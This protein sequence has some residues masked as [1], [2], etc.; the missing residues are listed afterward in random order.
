M[1]EAIQARFAG[2]DRKILLLGPFLK[3]EVNDIFHYDIEPTVFTSQSLTDLGKAGDKLGTPI[4]THLKLETGTNRQGITEKE[5]PEFAKIYKKYKSLDKPY[6]ASMH[7]ANIEDTTNHEYAE[8]QLKCFKALIQKMEKL[9]I[10]P[11]IRHTASSAALILFEKT[12]FDLVRPGISA[13]GHWPSKETYLS[14]RLEGG[15][16]NLFSPVLSLKSRITQ[17]KKLSADSFI[18]YGCTYRTTTPTT[19]AII[20][21]GYSD[22][23]DRNLSN[24]AY[25]LINGKRAPI[26]GRICMNLTMVDITDIKGVKIGDEVTLIGSDNSESITVEQLAGLSG[27]INY[28][29]LACINSQILR[30][31]SK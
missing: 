10:K 21:V 16:N 20:P 2:W 1:S 27:S 31:I 3:E 6:G 4:K 17:I 9:K 28:E 23:Y 29:T 14:Y 11:K 25:M 15:E 7:F 8:Q 18:G 19:L 26:R 12:R 22:G 30:Q 24:L 13:Y 5:L